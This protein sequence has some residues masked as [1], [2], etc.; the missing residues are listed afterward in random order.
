MTH[1]KVYIFAAPLQKQF[2]LFTKPFFIMYTLCGRG[3][4]NKIN[5][6]YKFYEMVLILLNSMELMEK[7]K[8]FS[9]FG[10]EK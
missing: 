2:F 4:D 6:R 1:E 10:D 7:N 9:Q 8:L 3:L 5:E